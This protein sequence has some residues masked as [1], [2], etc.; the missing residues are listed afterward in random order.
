LL[1]TVFLGTPAPAV[2]FLE[3]L[4]RKTRVVGVITSPDRPAGRGYALT[5]SPVKEAAAALA[6]P[7]FQPASLK[8]PDVL[9]TLKDWGP[10]DLGV[11]V[12]YGQLIPPAVF[13]FPRWG[14]TNVHFSLLPLYR[15]AA[16]VQ[17]ALIRGESETGV[18]LFRIEQGL[19]TGPIFLQAP[20]RIQPEDTS[21]GLRGRLV[22]LGLKLLEKALKGFETGSLSAEPQS[23]EPSWAPALK[24]SDGRI[25]WDQ[26]DAPDIV[27][28]IRGTYEWPGAFCLWKGQALKIRAAE[29]RPGNGSSPGRVL[30][31]EKGLG[32]VVRCRSDALLIRQVQP[33][34][35]KDMPAQDFWNGARL[36]PG[37]ALE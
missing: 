17:W 9:S 29:P 13:S 28:L 37:D 22:E 20:A 34:G 1:K 16:P 24:K 36:K 15:G 31:L 21:A 14:M 26:Q 6:L 3:L 7:V 2:P 5:E 19:D 18:T 33:E 10:V 8:S 12:A 23:G 4:R 32:F 35:K 30:G 11:V 25:R 27:N